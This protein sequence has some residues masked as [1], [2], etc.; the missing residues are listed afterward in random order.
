MVYQPLAVTAL[1]WSVACGLLSTPCTAAE[2]GRVT[3]AGSARESERGAILRGFLKDDELGSG[4][5]HALG[6]EQQ[7]AEIRIAAAAA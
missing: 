6:F 3:K 2:I 7:V 1:I 4:G 5:G